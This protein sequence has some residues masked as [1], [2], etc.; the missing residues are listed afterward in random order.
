MNK[1]AGGKLGGWGKP[2]T[3]V[4]SCCALRYCP[5]G[6]PGGLMLGRCVAA[7]C[8]VVGLSAL[9]QQAVVETA[10]DAAR[11]E[12]PHRI[13]VN[14]SSLPRLDAQDNSFQAPRVD[15]SLLP[16]GGSGLGVALGM[17]GLQP[18]NP[19][20][21]SPAVAATR[22]NLDV[23]LHFRQTVESR[24]VDVT[25]WRR[26]TQQQDV[27]LLAQQNAP[28]YGARVEMKLSPARTPLFADKGFVGLQLESGARIQ[29]KR[30]QGRP[31][32]YYRNS[33]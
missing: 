5:L 14:A 12:A 10:S 23:G 19:A 17:S 21:L 1:D 27:S 16:P 22:P 9:A 20:A 6:R 11:A 13:E 18:R 7:A 4:P 30:S 29:L 15:L 25:A 26:M 8:C 2:V 33:F 31:M 32:V 28:L 3:G 24:Q